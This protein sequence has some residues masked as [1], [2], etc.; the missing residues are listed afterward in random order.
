LFLKDLSNYKFLLDLFKLN[1]DLP[2]SDSFR[3]TEMLLNHYQS[4]KTLIMI[5]FFRQLP[6]HFREK[7]WYG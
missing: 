7:R 1:S 2:T 5:K 3:K 4:S 6:I